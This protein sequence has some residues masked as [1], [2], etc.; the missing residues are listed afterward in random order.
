MEHGLCPPSTLSFLTLDQL[1]LASDGAVSRSA[2][3]PSAGVLLHGVPH[4][5]RPDLPLPAGGAPSS[6][7]AGFVRFILPCLPPFSLLRRTL[8]GTFSVHLDWLLLCHDNRPQGAALGAQEDV[9]NSLHIFIAIQAHKGLAAYALGSSIVDSDA[10][11]PQ[12]HGPGLVKS[13]MDVMWPDCFEDP[14]PSELDCM[15]AAHDAARL[16]LTRRRASSG[17]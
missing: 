4:G 13:A 12:T 8:P 2:T 14:V 7:R 16:C 5:R 6:H 1:A 11:V 3:R 17:P 10:Q 9:V 15:S